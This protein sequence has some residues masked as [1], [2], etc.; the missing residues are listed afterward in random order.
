M[1][2]STHLTNLA[3][4]PHYPPT[5]SSSVYSRTTGGHEVPARN[6]HGHSFLPILDILPPPSLPLPVNH[7]KQHRSLFA[8]SFLDDHEYQ[9]PTE[10]LIPVCPPAP[11]MRCAIPVGSMQQPSRHS[12]NR[13][14][15]SDGLGF[16][17]QEV[18]DFL[19]IQIKKQIVED[20]G[21]LNHLKPVEFGETCSGK[22]G[23]PLWKA[24]TKYVVRFLSSL[25]F[26][27]F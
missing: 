26:S 22:F 12:R 20:V 15:E 11:R 10:D 27:C 8:A 16:L 17:S 1:E 6:V 19:G 13:H 14:V 5:P 23:T 7:S 3:I 9:L 4:R 21:Q 2:N 18:K 25:L 24:Q